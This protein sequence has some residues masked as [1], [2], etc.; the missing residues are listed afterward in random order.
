MNSN[1]FHNTLNFLTGVV[2][3]LAVTDY[4]TFGLTDGVAVKVVGGFVL[5]QSV[6]KL[7]VNTYRDG[8]TGLLSPQPPV[9]K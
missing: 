1:A 8:V 7:A 4:T 6:L 3:I 9:D 2:G 5:A